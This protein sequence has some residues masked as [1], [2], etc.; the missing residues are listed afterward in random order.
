M[1]KKDRAKMQLYNMRFERNQG[2]HI[3][4]TSMLKTA[5]N[6]ISIHN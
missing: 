2:I 3:S 6:A 5:E 4:Q 1:N